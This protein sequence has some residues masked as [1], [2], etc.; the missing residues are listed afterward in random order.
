MLCT[1]VMH[2]SLATRSLT[3]RG[4]DRCWAQLVNECPELLYI[5]RREHRDVVAVAGL[6]RL[7]V[8]PHAIPIVG[9]HFVDP[10]GL[11]ATARR[12]VEGDLR[13]AWPHA[14]A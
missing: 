7:P 10:D 12:P 11:Q 2:G 5:L 9:A 8:N 1:K 4:L 14:T 13:P 3:L 6:I